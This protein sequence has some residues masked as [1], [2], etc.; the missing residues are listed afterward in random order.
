M[1]ILIVGAG[2]TG[3]YFGACLATS[4]RDVS[5]L[6]REKRAAFLAE[7]GLRITGLEQ[8][9]RIEPRL[10]TAVTLAQ[11]SPAETFD[12]VLLT[13]KGSALKH[14]ISD[15]APAVGPNT[16][17]IPFL[18]GMAHMDALAAAFGAE[19]VL[20]S[21]AHL[22]GTINAEGDIELLSSMASWT[23][24]EQDE[25]RDGAQE[26][27]LSPRVQALV[28]E[29][30]VP[31]FAVLPVVDARI[32]LWKKW[33]FIVSAGVITCLM[34]G[35]VGAIAGVPGGKEF[36]AAVSAEAAAVA[37]AAGFALSDAEKADRIA[38]L[39]QEGSDFTSSLYR[40]VTAGLPNEGEHIVGDF[41][42]RASELGVA[43]PLID[44]GLIQLRV[45]EL[46][47]A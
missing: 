31:G 20:G 34:R 23:V 42:R 5:F 14:A 43:T 40:D 35:P 26:A 18:N 38:F 44:M 21:V 8:E 32:A 47:R 16:M 11:T 12:V 29:I 27:E 24:G 28:A 36:V 45:H 4:G 6:V 33:G 37:A 17:I 19:K 30:S 22:V 10:F 1:K 3:G 2:A 13:V 25:V 9:L 7:R 46:A 15:M 41:A 39:T